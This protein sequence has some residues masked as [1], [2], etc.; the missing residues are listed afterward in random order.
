[1]RKAKLYERYPLFQLMRFEDY[2]LFHVDHH[3]HLVTKASWPD[4]WYIYRNQ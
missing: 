2:H 4:Y 3:S 1:M